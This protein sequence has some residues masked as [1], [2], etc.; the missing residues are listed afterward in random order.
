MTEAL[1]SGKAK[2]S[3]IINSP[4]LTSGDIGAIGWLVDGA[5]S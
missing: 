1:R 3:T 5:A 2:C 4:T